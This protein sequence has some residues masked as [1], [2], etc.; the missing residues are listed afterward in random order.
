MPRATAVVSARMSDGNAT[1][2]A[3]FHAA[4][5]LLVAN[6]PKYALVLITRHDLMWNLPVSGWSPPA[7]FD[8]VSVFSRCEIANKAKYCINDWAY[9]M[10]G[11]LVLAFD[12]AMRRCWPGNRSKTSWGATG[13]F[14][15]GAGA[16]DCED[17]LRSTFN[18]SYLTDWQPRVGVREGGCPLANPIASVD[19]TQ[20]RVSALV[21]AEY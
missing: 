7:R 21:A 4:M 18:M 12:R 19:W 8:A 5:Q 14:K 17:T 9:V 11:K 10:P 3:S 6:A 16:H 1:Q 20:Q 15:S 2:A 13:A